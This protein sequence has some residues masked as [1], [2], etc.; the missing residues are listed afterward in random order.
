M[1]SGSDWLTNLFLYTFV[2]G[3]VFTLVSLLLGGVHIGGFGAHAHIHIGHIHIGGG[4]VGHAGHAG[5]IG[6]PGA[7]GHGQPHGSARMGVGREGIGHSADIHIGGHQSGNGDAQAV[8]SI[9][10]LN[11]PTIMAFL[12]WFGGAGYIFS[13]SLGFSHII[14][15]PMA[16]ASG[17]FGGGI[18]F[19]LLSRLLWPLMSKPLNRADFYLPGTPARVVSPIRA[20]G[21]GEIVYT[22]SGSRFTAGARNVDNRP[23]AKGTEVVILSY[24]RGVAYVEP[25]QD[26]LD[27]LGGGVAPPS[28]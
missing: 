14:L 13:R 24:E 26:V 3:L 21:V 12:T 18:M 8:D 22:K 28:S 25:V 16:L 10:V 27:R 9:G 11:M 17:L 5:H 2:F 1:A 7:S 23:I 6:H 4:H 15:V 19:I 20:G